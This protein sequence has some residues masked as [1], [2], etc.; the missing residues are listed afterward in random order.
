VEVISDIARA[1]EGSARTWQ[2]SVGLRRFWDEARSLWGSSFT[3]SDIRDL[4]D[5]VLVLGELQTRGTASGV[6]LDTPVAYVFE[7]DEGLIRKVRLYM[8]PSEALKAVGLEE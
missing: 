3:T 1:V 8:D 4:G 2:G 7:F 5:T 6:A